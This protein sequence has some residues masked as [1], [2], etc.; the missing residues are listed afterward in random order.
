MQAEAVPPPPP[1]GL[2]LALGGWYVQA[3]ALLLAG[4]AVH[5]TRGAGGPIPGGALGSATVAPAGV[6]LVAL[7][8][9]TGLGVLVLGLGHRFAVLGLVVSGTLGTWALALSGSWGVVVVPPAMLLGLVP[10]L[11]ARTNEHLR[12]RGHR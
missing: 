9:L 4:L 10:L 2:K 11:G 6:V 1:W 5:G 7:A 12:S 8:F 3:A